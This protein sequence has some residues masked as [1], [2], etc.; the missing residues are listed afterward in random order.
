MSPVAPLAYGP[1]S[2][3]IG[4]PPHVIDGELDVEATAPTN[5]K[6]IHNALFV[7]PFDPDP[8]S[9]DTPSVVALPLPRLSAD[10]SN[11]TVP[12]TTAASVIVKFV[13]DR[14]IELDVMAGLKNV[15]LIAPLL[16]RASGKLG[17]RERAYR[18]RRTETACA[19]KGVGLL[20]QREAAYRQQRSDG[21]PVPPCVAAGRRS[22]RK[23]TVEIGC[24][25]VPCRDNARSRAEVDRT[26]SGYVHGRRP[27]RVGRDVSDLQGKRRAIDRDTKP[28]VG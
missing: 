20:G 14:T 12:P 16:D 21:R 19:R 6:A 4:I 28:I 13:F 15:F 17:H 8:T 7:V 22:T 27:G 24:R 2:N 1:P 9:I 10:V 26:E 5:C 11:K 23:G 3:V 18:Q 25:D